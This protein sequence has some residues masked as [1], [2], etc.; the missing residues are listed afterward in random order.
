M[1]QYLDGRVGKGIT[2][3]GGPRKFDGWLDGWWMFWEKERERVY[4]V[5][6]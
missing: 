2:G 1:S 6:S 4:K 3:K 5:L